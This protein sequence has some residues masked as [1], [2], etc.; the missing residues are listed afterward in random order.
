M[1]LVIVIVDTLRVGHTS[2]QKSVSQFYQENSLQTEPT[3]GL[4]RPQRGMGFGG[5][6]EQAVQG[7][8]VTHGERRGLF[9]RL[10]EHLA[11]PPTW[12]HVQPL[13]GE[14]DSLSRAVTVATCVPPCP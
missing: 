3:S 9:R 10:W 6:V 1:V 7:H 14:P 13:A 8:G 2:R 11:P 5:K 4:Y 12:A